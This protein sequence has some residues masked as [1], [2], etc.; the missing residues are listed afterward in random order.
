[1]D[2]SQR[3]ASLPGR[4]RIAFGDPLHADD[5]IRVTPIQQIDPVVTVG[6]QSAQLVLIGVTFLCN[7][8]IDQLC[9]R[10]PSP[11]GVGVVGRFS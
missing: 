5:E 4:D 9:P 11:C 1:M 2:D 6:D 7:Q 10:P 8:V 3:P